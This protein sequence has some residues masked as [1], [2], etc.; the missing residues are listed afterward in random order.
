MKNYKF[1]IIAFIAILVVPTIVWFGIKY[2]SPSTY[3]KLNYDL[4]EKRERTTIESIDQLASSGDVLAAYF[5]DRA[6]FRSSLVSLYQKTN[7]KLEEK[8]DNE[9]KPA[10]MAS[11][12]GTSISEIDSDDTAFN[13]LFGGDTQADSQGSTSDNTG[14]NGDDSGTDDSEDGSGNGEEV[15]VHDWVYAGG[16]DASVDSWGYSIYFCSTCNLVEYRDWQNKLV[17]ESYLAPVVVNDTTIMGRNGWLFLYGYGNISYY[18]AENIMTEEEM[19]SYMQTLLTLDEL[20]QERGIKLAISIAPNKDQ[21]YSEYMPTYTV[22]DE[23]KRTQRLVDYIKNNSDLAISYPIS[24]LEY[25]DRY[26]KIYYR[27]DT[28][29]NHVGGFI[30]VQALYASLGMEVTDPTTIPVTQYDWGNVGDLIDLAGI[31]ASSYAVDVDYHIWYKDEVEITNELGVDYNIA[32]IYK[33]QSDCGNDKRL[34]LIGDS[35]RINMIQYLE[36]DFGQSAF[37]NRE[38]INSANDDILNCDVLVLQAN[39]RN[40]ARIIT[41]AQYIIDLFTN[42]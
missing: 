34:V 28:H 6:P 1:K 20:C 10:I 39:E 26:W 15:H 12:Y 31:D 2:I 3:E 8:Y 33:A 19:D 32:N 27:Y 16:Q 11:L 36:A 23:Y 9:L 24:E 25:C 7:T 30:G 29:W 35:Y 5:A 38:V 21:V 4:G 37:Y 13:E 22:L 41:S 14:S 42:Q 17:D 40:D 18:K